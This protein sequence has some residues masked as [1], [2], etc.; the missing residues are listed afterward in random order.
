MDKVEDGVVWVEDVS[1]PSDGLPSTWTSTI[2]LRVS[3]YHLKKCCRE[4]CSSNK[5]SVTIRHEAMPLSD[6][7]SRTFLNLRCCRYIQV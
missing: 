7:E 2:C 5:N 4:S 6:T 3:L 1:S